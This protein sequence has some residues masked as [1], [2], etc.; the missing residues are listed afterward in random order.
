MEVRIVKTKYNLGYW[1]KTLVAKCVVWYII[2]SPHR[3]LESRELFIEGEGGGWTSVQ[4][5]K[6]V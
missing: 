1:N 6:G 2:L 3:V 4:E 5:G